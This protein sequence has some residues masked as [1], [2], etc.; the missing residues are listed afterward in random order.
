MVV[1]SMDLRSWLRKQVEDSDP[2]LLREI[3]H[4][5]AEAL[6]GADADTAC[7]AFYGERSS[8]R[9]N[10]RNGYRGAGTRAS[11]PSTSPSPSCGPEATSPSGSWSPVVEP[12]ERSSP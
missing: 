10:S 2:D 12:S 7:N 8:E 4:A 9:T 6:M 1:P 11:A 3:V 5:M